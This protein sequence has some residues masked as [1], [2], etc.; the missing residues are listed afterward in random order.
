MA[1]DFKGTWNVTSFKLSCGIL[2]YKKKYRKKNFAFILNIRITGHSQVS[3]YRSNSAYIDNLIYCLM[4]YFPSGTVVRSKY[5]YC[6]FYSINNI[7]LSLRKGTWGKLYEKKCWTPMGHCCS[8]EWEF[9]ACQFPFITVDRVLML[10]LLF[11]LHTLENMR[12][13][14]NKY[15]C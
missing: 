15:Y 6:F 4:F 3:I 7:F 13:E 2:N 9:T 10:L 12:L 11:C 8:S 5:I 14:N 1:V